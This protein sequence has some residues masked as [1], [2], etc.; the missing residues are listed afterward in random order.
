[1]LPHPDA[2]VE[3]KGVEEGLRVLGA[4]QDGLVLGQ[5]QAL[6]QGGQEGGWL[7]R[8]H[9]GVHLSA[10]GGR[11]Q[12]GSFRPVAW[13]DRDLRQQVHLDMVGSKKRSATLNQI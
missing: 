4:A 2:D 3:D 8:S 13:R 11:Q 10:Q 1:M 7:A 5:Q 9:V 6:L 12:R